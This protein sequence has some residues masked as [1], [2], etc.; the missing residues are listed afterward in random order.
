MTTL[1]A[2]RA[3]AVLKRL[4]R[5]QEPFEPKPRLRPLDE[6][7]MTVLSQHT[8]DSNTER[9][10]AS[11]RRRF[12]T[13]EEVRAAPVRDVADAIRSGGL[14]EQKAPRLK[15]ILDEIAAREGKVSLDRLHSLPDDEIETYLV[16]LPGVGPKTA[17]CVLCFSLGRAA[18]PVDTHVHRV[19]L[20]LGWIP[21]KTSAERAHLVLGQAIPPDARY[22]LHVALIRHGRTTCTARRPYCSDCVL[23]DWCP[24][25]TAFLAA[26]EAR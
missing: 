19:A 13:W 11:L 10:F 23:F 24:S 14:A 6:L 15:A 21:P 12:R 22:P 8:S 26:G 17:A 2:R 16:S 25:G 7:I 1:T 5:I 18:F 3:R 20:R 9:A 4:Q